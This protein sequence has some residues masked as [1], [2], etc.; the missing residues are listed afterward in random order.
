MKHHKLKQ[1]ISFLLALVMIVAICPLGSFA[2]EKD[3]FRV[4]VSIEGLTLG[5]GIY[6][7]PEAYTLDQINE[8]VATKG[9]GP[10]TEDTLTAAM[11]TLA[12]FV[13]NHIE[14]TNTGRWDNSFYLSG[15]KGVDNG[16]IDI[17]AFIGEAGGATNAENDG[18]DDEYLGEFDYDSMAGWMITCNHN[19][20]S[21][22]AADWI[23]KERVAGGAGEN[24]GN[25]YNVRWQFTVHGYGADL[26]HSTGWGNSAM[27]EA[28]NKDRLY[29]AYATSTDEAAKAAA[30]PVMENLTASQQDVDAATAKLNQ[31]E[32][33]PEVPAEPQD[34]SAV[35]HQAMEQLATK[36]TTP[37]FGTSAGEWTVLGL[38][39][40]G[41]YEANAPYFQEYYDR[42]VVA[43]DEKASK[44]AAQNGALHRAKSTDNSRLILAL[45]SIGKE[46]TAV[47]KWNLI[48]PFDD[49]KWIQKQGING[50]IFALI[51]LDTH[52][53]A[54]TD[55]TIRQQCVDYILSKELED[56]GWALSGKVSDPDITAMALQALVNYKD[57]PA[58]AA[59]AEKAFA[60]LS[61]AQLEQ[62]GYASW[63]TT[64][65]ESIAQVITACTAWGINPDTDSRFIKNGKSA[66][67]A[68]LT[69]YNA[70]EK[71]FHH[72]MDNGVDAM[73]TDQGI[74]A[75]VAY[76]RLL[77]GKT[78]LY[79]MSDVVF[80][81][82]EGPVEPGDAKLTASL[83][84]P[85]K[86]ERIK[87]TKFNAEI[88]IDR[89]D[90]T[91]DYKLIDFM[92]TVPKGLSVKSVTAGERLGGGEVSY[93]VEPQEDGTGKLRVVYFDPNQ[94]AAITV[95]G[96]EFP[97]SLFQIGFVVEDLQKE[98][99]LDLALNGM[100]IKLNSDSSS[101]ASM[102]IVNTENTAHRIELVDGLSFSAMCLYQGDD[103][104]L[105]G[106]NQKA[107][108][109]MATGM[110][111]Q[112]KLLYDDQTH[113]I[114]FLHNEA[115]AQKMGTAAYIALVDA[116]IPMEQF[117]KEE[118]YKVEAD[119]KANA[120]TFGDANADGVI[121]AQD[122][123]A[124]VDAWL[125]K[126]TAPTDNQI[127]A[128]NV[129]G[130]SR[131]NTFDALG[132]VESFVNNTEFAV[133]TKAVIPGGNR[134][135]AA[136]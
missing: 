40:G 120:I 61:S 16:V 20:I 65:S 8:L 21:A 36:V 38:A 136:A 106:A 48:T 11:A 64:N 126:G 58:V 114:A 12:F 32:P 37:N 95:S 35:L 133:V 113:Q 67:D 3:D 53:Y 92:V 86:I 79:D 109:V 31:P 97:A 30:L 60:W 74:Y 10:Y 121:N 4:V 77:K 107:V 73:A 26:G 89:W 130:D 46:A 76:D 96:T 110:E 5:Q 18:N 41:F 116:S 66:V 17:P 118:N 55:P 6:Y 94:N 128:L 52:D 34:V 124:A 14:Y 62:G 105:I 59:A 54:T 134:V 75:L 42:I 101:D 117:T 91:A 90:N 23:L 13:D 123:L 70:E 29:A 68:L 84:V 7:G 57:Q 25:T 69:F 33:K 51:A 115:I 80:A 88:A 103:V 44:I 100:S 9:Y 87:G 125:R 131:I 28:A 108:V 83:G 82:A 56:G 78:S 24:Y 85:E 81:G 43:V 132:I 104:D 22:G 2:A 112:E 39:R 50:P 129:N 45:S 99:Y 27:F 135:S 102:I 49:F 98:T 111:P 15:V 47:G 19:M 119:Q 71:A 72:V 93:H 127:L 1:A 122:A 63:G